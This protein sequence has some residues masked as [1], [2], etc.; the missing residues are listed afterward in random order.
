VIVL[1]AVAGAFVGYVYSTDLYPD[2]I[3]SV[4]AAAPVPPPLDPSVSLEHEP[5]RP[6]ANLAHEGVEA[7]TKPKQPTDQ[8]PRR[9]TTAGESGF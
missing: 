4:A 8:R 9:D 3:P 7:A 5:L 2:V 1:A 6:A